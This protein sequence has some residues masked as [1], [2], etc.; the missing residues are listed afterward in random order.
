[1][2]KEI[3][4]EEFIELICKN[5]SEKYLAAKQYLNSIIKTNKLNDNE[6]MVFKKGI[7][8]IDKKL[9]GKGVDINKKANATALNDVKKS[10]A[11]NGGGYSKTFN[12]YNES[13][14]ETFLGPMF[15]F[16]I[17][18]AIIIFVVALVATIGALPLELIGLD[19]FI[20]KDAL[21]TI[22]IINSIVLGGLGVG[23][24]KSKNFRS[25][26]KNNWKK[27]LASL[28]AVF[29]L[30]NGAKLI[31]EGNISNDISNFF[32]N[33]KASVENFVDNGISSIDSLFDNTE[34]EV[35]QDNTEL[36][37][38]EKTKADYARIISTGKLVAPKET[39]K[40]E[41]VSSDNMAYIVLKDFIYRNMDNPNLL[42]VKVVEGLFDS[43]G[44]LNI[45]YPEGS[46]NYYTVN[47]SMLTKE[48]KGEILGILSEYFQN[49]KYSE[50]EYKNSIVSGEDVSFT[51]KRYHL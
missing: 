47:V 38:G 26:V 14:S 46:N 40:E 45:S 5:D 27:I 50:Y 23:L 35:I 8:Y 51:L 43:E 15:K 1:M 22:G 30:G 24:V 4:I 12:N 16:I 17:I 48:E 33:T 44:S 41:T 13:D 42:A 37:S 7:S 19:V 21:M 31:K 10:F 39:K 11:G 25:K 28:V 29:C 6:V 49:Y 32:N 18:V 34:E 3:E 36:V 20:S 2:K 9:K